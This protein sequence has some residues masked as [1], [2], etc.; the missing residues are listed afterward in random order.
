MPNR[1]PSVEDLTS[2]AAALQDLLAT[3]AKYK[4][5][6]EK[7][8]GPLDNVIPQRA[9]QDSLYRLEKLFN[10]RRLPYG[11][12]ELAGYTLRAWPYEVMTACPKL[13]SHVYRIIQRWD[14]PEICQD[15]L[16]IRGKFGITQDDG[17]IKEIDRPT[18]P[19][20]LTPVECE[21]LAWVLNAL[22][23]SLRA[24]D[25]A[26]PNPAVSPPGA[27]GRITFPSTLARQ[28]GASRPRRPQP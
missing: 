19:Y 25:Q 3:F 2:I 15:R 28:S 26:T 20:T 1:I 5:F 16:I 6:L 7:P 23:D 17:T 13:K 18:H 9:M 22:L 27:Q 24:V 4:L 21:E 10:P 8:S 14:I 12:P 11:S